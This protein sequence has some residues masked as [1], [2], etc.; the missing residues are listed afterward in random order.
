MTLY[1]ATLVLSVVCIIQLLVC[2]SMLQSIRGMETTISDLREQN[3]FLAN[4]IDAFV[5]SNSD[6]KTDGEAAMQECYS[7]RDTLR[8]IHALSTPGNGSGEKTT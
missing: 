2:A 6:S 8:R 1:V 3:S 5:A 7:M 4:E